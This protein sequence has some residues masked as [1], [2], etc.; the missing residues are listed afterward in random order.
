MASVT[1]PSAG[2]ADGGEVAVDWVEHRH[3]G[4]VLRRDVEV[5][6]VGFEAVARVDAP[7]LLVV[8]VDDHLFALAEPLRR[9][10]ALP[11]TQHGLAIELLHLQVARRIAGGHR[12]KPDHVAGFV[13]DH[14][15]VLT[16]TRVGSGE[17]VSRRGLSRARR[18]HERRRLQ[19]RARVE[20]L[21]LGGVGRDVPRGHVL[22]VV[23]RRDDEVES[24]RLRLAGNRQPAAYVDRLA[25]VKRLGRNEARAVAL[26]VGLQAPAVTA[27]LASR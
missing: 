4:R 16:R 11:P 15:P 14:R 12:V 23:R 3:H 10:V 2:A 27:R 17:Q 7:D 8:A 22:E 1:A 18:D 21:H 25:G 5:V 24:E 20:A 9:D 6:E 13:E 19:F 26:R